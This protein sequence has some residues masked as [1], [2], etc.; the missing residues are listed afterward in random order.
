MGT[1]RFLLSAAIAIGAI[2]GISAASAADLPMKAPPP[3]PVVATWTGFYWGLNLGYSWGKSDDTSTLTNALGFNFFNN[4][5]G[6]NMNGVVGG[7]QI[8][9]NWQMGNWVVGLELDVQ[10]TGQQGNRNFICPAGF[11]V[12][13]PPG[14]LAVVVGT[15]LPVAM[16]QKLEWF[17]TFRGRAGMLVTPTLLVYGTG[18]VASGGINTSEAAGVVSTSFFDKSINY[19]WTAGAGIEGIIAPN[20]TAKLEYLYV[21]LGHVSGTFFTP[22]AAPGGGPVLANYNSRITDNILRV[23]INYK[24]AQ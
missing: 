3:P 15:P 19:G 18:G 2:S 16:N 5:N 6:T 4:P 7:T 11:C 1:S 20:W 24:F 21:D 13:T 10:G 8:G 17:G 9:S 22:I 12:L 23:G 14:N